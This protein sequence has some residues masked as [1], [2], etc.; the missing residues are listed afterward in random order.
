MHWDC[1]RSGGRSKLIAQTLPNE[2][3]VLEDQSTYTKATLTGLE[4]EETNEG[5]VLGVLLNKNTDTLICRFDQLI[6]LARKLPPNKR[7]VLRL[8]ASVFDPLGIVSP[9]IM[10]TK[11]LFQSLCSQ[12]YGWDTPLS[13]E[14]IEEHSNVFQRWVNYVNELD[15]IR[16]IIVP[17][18]YAYE[19]QEYI[20][21][22]KL[23]G[24]GD[25]SVKGN[26]AVVIYL[27]YQSVQWM[28]NT[29][30]SMLN[31]YH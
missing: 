31:M 22:Y 4:K 26:C 2:R 23:V 30:E 19:V 27:V 11:L 17:R 8:T 3:V 28:E 12:N 16:S 5:K 1:K 15:N 9:V 7:N 20:V 18:Y 10:Q 14:H 29:E 24:F 6:E 13:G 25:S 21:R